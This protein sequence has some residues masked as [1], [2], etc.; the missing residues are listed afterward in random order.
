MNF[1]RFHSQISAFIRKRRPLG[2]SSFEL[3]IHEE[4]V[5]QIF[6]LLSKDPSGA[7]L[8]YQHHP[9]VEDSFRVKQ[10]SFIQFSAIIRYHS[11][12][13]AWALLFHDIAKG[14]LPGPHPQRSYEVVKECMDKI[15][16]LSLE[17]SATD[18]DRM[19]WLIRYHDLLGNIY[20]GERAPNFLLDILSD[21]DE[22]ERHLRI[23]LLQFVTLC[24]ML[25]MDGGRYLTEP[26]V[27]FWLSLSEDTFVHALQDDLFS[28]RIRRWAGDLLGREDATKAEA[29]RFR[30]G[31]TQQIQLVEQ[32]FGPV[33]GYI[34]YG[35]YLFSALSAE[36]VEDLAD[37]LSTIAQFVIQVVDG[38]CYS[39]R[40]IP[41]R[42]WDV[43][44]ES[45]L[46]MYREKIRSDSLRLEYDM[47]TSE[48][49]VF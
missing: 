26:K 7:L 5:L 47:K 46:K 45:I 29:L 27:R 36:G 20:T 8:P 12:L 31:Q 10:E 35:F 11:L 15:A 38:T 22:N 1:S 18:A 40:F 33:T 30:L 2:L 25:G 3:T 43:S 23:R 6:R 14:R 13:L 49:K 4:A 16:E 39:I 28:Y 21:L 19:Q 42:P 24:D 34:Q 41:Y 48:L 44:T 17:L 32:V 9:V 37:L